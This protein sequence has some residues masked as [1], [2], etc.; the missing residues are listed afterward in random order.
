MLKVEIEL[1]ESQGKG[2]G[3]FAKNLIPKNTKIWEFTPGMDVEYSLDSV[4]LM[5]ELETKFLYKYAYLENNLWIVCIDEARHIN[6]STTPN[7]YDNK[8]GTFAKQNIKAGEE[9][10][11]NYF[12]ICNY[13]KE[14]GLD[15]E[16]K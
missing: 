1:K 14:H 5:N 16:P 15:F 12:E 10:T 6:H 3:L 11:S 13:V 4:K 8:E 7:T 9:I 2:I